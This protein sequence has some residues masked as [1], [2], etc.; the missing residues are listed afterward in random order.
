MFYFVAYANYSLRHP[1]RA[2]SGTSGAISVTVLGGPS[3]PKSLS[4]PS[5]LQHGRESASLVHHSVG[6]VGT[7]FP[8]GPRSLGPGC[9]TDSTRGRRRS[10][11]DSSSSRFLGDEC[12]S[13]KTKGQEAWS[14]QHDRTSASGHR[15]LRRLW[16]Q[17]PE[18]TWLCQRVVGGSGGSGARRHV[19]RVLSLFRGC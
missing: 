6:S 7:Q 13:G 17:R 10:V 11:P 18:R 5:G 12:G 8:H 9:S 3:L 16:D 1:Q 19:F 15:A 2:A 4:S 14:L